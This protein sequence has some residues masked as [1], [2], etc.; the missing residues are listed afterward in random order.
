MKIQKWL[1][2]SVLALVML[3]LLIWGVLNVYLLRS[4]PLLDG[5]FKLAGISAPVQVVRDTSDV[6][7]IHAATPMDAWRALGLVHA[8]ERGWQLAFNRQLMHGELSAWFG[9]STLDTDKLIRTLGIVQ[10]AQAQYDRLPANAKL[11]LQAYSQG[12]QAGYDS[13]QWRA[14]EFVLLGLNPGL[15]APAW[16]PVDSVAWSLMMALDLGGNWGQE[17]A[18]L[19]SAQ[20]LSTDELWQLIPPY[21]GL[22]KGTSVDLAGLYASLGVYAKPG[23]AFNAT[24]D[25]TLDFGVVE[26]KGSNNW[27][28]P[29]SRTQSGQAL[30]ANDPHLGLSAAAIWY[31]VGLH[32]PAGKF[33][34]GT[35]H[36]ALEVVG[37]SLPGL[38]FVVLGRTD[39]VAWGFTNTGPD[40]QD[41]YLEELILASNPGQNLTS[42]QYKGIDG[43]QAFQTREEVFKIK[44]QGDE[45]ITVRT[46]RHGP[47]I[48]DVQPI[49]RSFL[50]M[51]RYAV[52]LKWSAL[53]PDNRTVLAGM[54]ANFAKSV[55]DLKVAYADHLA[56]MQSVVMA[57]TRGQVLFKAVGKVPIR[58]ATNDLQGLAPAPGWLAKYDWQGWLPYEKTPEQSTAQIQ[59]TGG[60][61]TANQNI[62][63]SGYKHF[64]GHDWTNPERFDRITALLK[65][66]SIHNVSSMKSIQGDALSLAAVRLLP[67]MKKLESSH[68]LAPKAKAL[69]STFKGEMSRESAAALIYAVWADELTQALIKPKLGEARFK[70]LFGKRHFRA[71]VEGILE[72]NDPAWCG[73]KGC[74]AQMN[75]AFDSALD[76][77]VSMQ[78]RDP[79]LWNWGQAHPALSSHKPFGNVK[80]F[81]PW[82][83]VSVPSAGDAFT[84]N[85]GQYWTNSASMP[86]ASRH[87]ASMRAVYDLSN[88]ENSEFIYQAGQSGHPF[89]RRYQSMR[90]EWA[91][92]QLRPLK[93]KDVP[94]V[95]RQA[96]SV[97]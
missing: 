2:R 90:D 36:A 16:T 94:A 38:P 72:R 70:A 50:N 30:L 56:P 17:F 47:V 60:L 26:G 49:Y 6:T 75:A 13:G 42:T 9:P 92:V 89:S 40:V 4:M 84:V 91:Q 74:Q 23:V 10:T 67:A 81:A 41:L 76:R 59:A 86:F 87:A 66:K 14:P 96:L 18:R 45:R 82:F 61:A 44:G 22:S 57:D 54:N 24:Q 32:A 53:D 65:D 12:I 63:P 73:N 58:H 79:S 68:A 95:H 3:L 33:P 43:P 48:S 55:D 11:A 15:S 35:A 77:I 83:D 27:V 34:D 93:L 62:L 28:L 64:I 51:D 7:H 80:A 52:A 25:S 37:A 71:A 69:L 46:T 5:Q 85:V 29:G 1:L 21:P 31:F 88:L 78:G 8:Q 19:M 39:Q 97:D 20:V